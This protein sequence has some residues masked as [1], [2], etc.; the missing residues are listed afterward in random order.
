MVTLCPDDLSNRGMLSFS[1]DLRAAP[2][3]SLISV[4]DMREAGPCD[5]FT[6]SYG[7][8]CAGA[9]SFHLGSGE[10]DHLAPFFGFLDEELP[11]ISG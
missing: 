2:L 5:G 11:E 10:L 6:E 1:A 3:R 4:E 8:R 9:G 7:A